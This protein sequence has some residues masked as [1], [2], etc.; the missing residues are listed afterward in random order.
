MKK[1]KPSAL[2]LALML[3]GVTFASM[4]TFAA[5]EDEQ[6][7]NAEADVEVIEVRG[8]RRSLIESI[9]TK[10]Y[11]DTVVEAVSADDMGA[12]PDVS[13]ADALSRLP[14]VTSVRQ[15]GQSSELNIRG[16]SGNY[17]FAT[18][19]GRE[20]VSNEGGR[21]VQFDQYPS[22][23]INSAQVYK[24][25]KA[26][27]I[28]GGVAGTIELQTINPLDN[29]DTHSFSI[30]GKLSYNDSESAEPHPEVSSE[31][32][33]LSLAYQG[34]FLDETLGFA[35]GYSRLNQPKIHT[36]FTNYTPDYK[37]LPFDGV[38]GACVGDTCGYYSYPKGFEYM[39]RGGDDTRDGVVSTLTFQ[40]NDE[41]SIKLDAFYSKFDSESF[42]R[43]NRLDS[44]ALDNPKFAFSDQV[45]VDDNI[46]VGGTY[47]GD[48]ENQL[49]NYPDF[50][51]Q[52]PFWFETQSDTSS[53]ESE[54]FTLGGNV[55]YAADD[56]TLS[57]DFSHSKGESL[58]LDGVMRLHL[59]NDARVDMPVASDNIDVRYELNGLEMP[60]IRFDDATTAGLVD[61]NRMMVTAL[62]KYPNKEDNEASS[63]KLDFTYE[64][65]TE[66]LSSI[67]TGLRWSE[68]SHVFDRKMYFLGNHSSQHQP[69][70]NGDYVITWDTSDPANIVPATMIKPYQLSEG[71]YEVVQLGGSFG[72]YPAFL[73]IDNAAIE[74]AWYIAQG[75]DT[76]AVKSHASDWTYNQSVE[77]DEEI[78]AVYVQANLNAEIGDYT[79]TGN[80][81]V[82]VVETEQTS[83]GLRKSSSED[84]PNASCITD[85]Y[86][87]TEC[88]WME[89]TDGT[90]YTDVLPSINLNLQLSES[91]QLR[92]AAAEVMARPEMKEMRMSGTWET[93]VEANGEVFLD[94]KDSTN[95]RRK[96]FYATQYDLS[97]EHYFTETEGAF[98]F[99]LFYKDIKAKTQET[100]LTDFD[101][102]SA[103]IIVPAADDGGAPPKPGNY[104][105]TITS[106][107]AGWL[108]G[109]EIAYTQ[110]FGF[111]PEPFSGLG[112]SLNYSYTDSELTTE[113]SLG[114]TSESV[115][116]PLNGLS[117][118][119]WTATL[120]YDYEGFATR[121]NARYRDDY[122][123]DQVE[124]G[125]TKQ[126]YFNE[127][128]IIDYQASYQ[129]T[130][131]VQGIFS[132]NNLTDEPNI[133]YFGEK[134]ATGTIQEFG[135]QF[136]L[137]FNA[138]F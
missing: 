110:T 123:G 46:I 42:D 35:I 119:V 48:P 78:M 25:Q 24:S 112:I 105:T 100:T 3:G 75:H 50:N 11:S 12:L 129:F 120:F 44:I 17:V 23:L 95:P 29:E 14:G 67:E 104:T 121:L 31:G 27:L 135:R 122:I 85:G 99:A 130:E 137:G 76:T 96:P 84:D 81:G 109:Y 53:V 138:K 98:V 90:D 10:R 51:G 94:L 118:E 124:A 34:K 111:L 114:T 91:D 55:T 1:F 33:R 101:F 97:Y 77:V 102:A 79:L 43:G 116:T 5:E 115:T 64:L 41:L 103:G 127:E 28:E 86:G 66:F 117:K 9:N 26:S 59:F 36:T 68:R 72:D 52:A 82:R 56:W 80:V 7:A 54:V 136:Y 133:S 32:H 74:Q 71:E 62:E 106:E 47:S 40:P 20:V 132:I 61:P 8:F 107:D 45:V 16:L 18:L 39:A 65:D 113:I 87:V 2:S 19:N 134:Y 37:A 4:P 21:S 108:K 125:A 38:D 73:A 70:R 13:I 63:V 131:A 6:K 83:T 93:R 89:V 58:S 22:E 126:V 57:A 88:G 30:Q 128:M 15:G 69:R 92:F 49:V 60:T